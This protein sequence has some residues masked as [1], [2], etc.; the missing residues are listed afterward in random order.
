MIINHIN[1]LELA[2]VLFIERIRIYP[3]GSIIQVD[4]LYEDL[5]EK[6]MGELW[7]YFV[8]VHIDYSGFLLK[9]E[10]PSFVTPFFPI[11]RLYRTRLT[12]LKKYEDFEG[13]I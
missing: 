10:E 13:L 6:I 12:L 2:R 1:P 5:D 9:I 8:N 11:G 3:A 4:S 7:S